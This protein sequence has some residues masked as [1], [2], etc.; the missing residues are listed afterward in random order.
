MGRNN[1]ARRGEPTC[2]G[3]DMARSGRH[4][5]S[6]Q[7][8]TQ[9]HTLACH[10]PLS[11]LPRKQDS[12]RNQG[13]HLDAA[14]LAREVLLDARQRLFGDIYRAGRAR[15][16]LERPIYTRHH[17]ARIDATQRKPFGELCRISQFPALAGG[18]RTGLVQQCHSQLAKLQRA[19]E[20]AICPIGLQR[21]QLPRA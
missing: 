11:R 19:S 9:G 12:G 7:H 5:Q 17:I 4:H 3:C 20:Q 13:C 8:R 2:G 15:L 21:L 6:P 18:G 16:L 1:N 10:Q 14:H